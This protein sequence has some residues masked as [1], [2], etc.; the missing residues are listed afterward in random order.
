MGSSVVKRVSYTINI[1]LVATYSKSFIE[2]V[3][4]PAAPLLGS[5]SGKVIRAV[6]KCS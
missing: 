2:N 4:G 5:S 6:Q 1:R 3:L